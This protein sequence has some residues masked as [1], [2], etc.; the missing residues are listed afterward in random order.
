MEYVRGDAI[1][2]MN[3]KRSADFVDIKGSDHHVN[4]GLEQVLSAYICWSSN[5]NCGMPLEEDTEKTLTRGRWAGD[6]FEVM[7]QD[8]MPHNV[9]WKDVTPEAVAWLTKLWQESER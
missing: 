7:H 4:M 1:K 5:S 9:S 2:K 8:R 3:D 6:R